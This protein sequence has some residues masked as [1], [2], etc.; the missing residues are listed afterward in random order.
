MIR[1]AT[2]DDIGTMQA[3]EV[4]AGEQFR[5]VGMDSI[6]DAEPFDADEL[7]AY[8]DAGTA[9]VAD[10]DGVVVGY[11]AAE[12][13]DGHGHLEQVSVHPSVQGRG[14]GRALIDAV[15]EW[16]T[17]DV[18]LTTFRDVPWNQPLYEHLGFVVLGDDEIGPELRAKVAHEAELGLDP[19]LRVVMSLLRR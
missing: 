4:A 3:I 5:T 2:I 10:V 6:A 1:L 14:V 18:T 8:V 19:A 12:V 9:W 15:V 11:A 17:G 16:S 7:G 13:V